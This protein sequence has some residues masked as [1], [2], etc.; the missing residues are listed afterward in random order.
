[1]DY[2]EPH[3]I[4]SKDSERRMQKQTGNERFT[5]GLYRNDGDV[6]CL[7]H[8]FTHDLP[9]IPNKEWQHHRLQSD[10]YFTKE[11]RIDTP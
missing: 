8:R 2:A 6:L 1:L 5:I 10:A 4:L 7:N 3:P 11:S 9:K